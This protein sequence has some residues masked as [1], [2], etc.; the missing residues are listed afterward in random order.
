MLIRRDSW[1]PTSLRSARIERERDFFVIPNLCHGHPEQTKMKKLQSNSLF[2]S[3]HISIQQ[4]DVYVPTYKKRALSDS[5]FILVCGE[6]GILAHFSNVLTPFFM[7]LI[8]LR[9]R[10]RDK[11]LGKIICFSPSQ[12]SHIILSVLHRCNFFMAKMH[13]NQH[14]YIHLTR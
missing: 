6:R 12:T 8:P 2:V 10:I 9:I 3:M 13:Q 1:A 7:S 4:V 5:F 14:I 11:F